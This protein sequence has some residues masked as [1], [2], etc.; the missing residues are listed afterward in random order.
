MKTTNRFDLYDLSGNGR[1]CAVSM[2]QSRSYRNKKG[3]VFQP[4]RNE[5]QQR[6]HFIHSKNNKFNGKTNF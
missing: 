6:H 3:P 5:N 2:A 1:L 4:G